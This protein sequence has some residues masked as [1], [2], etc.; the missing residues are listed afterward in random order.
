MAGSYESLGDLDQ[1]NVRA[2]H[3]GDRR[4]HVLQ[5]LNYARALTAGN[6]RSSIPNRI[7][8]AVSL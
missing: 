6:F 5:A 1:I 2:R 7:G 8:W 3:A 4:R